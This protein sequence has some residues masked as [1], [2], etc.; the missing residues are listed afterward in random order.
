MCIS[1]LAV[2]CRELSR[3][4]G[5]H[6]AA[7]LSPTKLHR[8]G[9]GARPRQEI[10]GYSRCPSVH[11]S[12]EAIVAHLAIECRAT[13]VEALR[14]FRHVTAIATEREADHVRLHVLE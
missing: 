8:P 4:H 2:M 5:E 12:F 10:V 14:H 3:T 7:T 13:D 6:K 11:A 9:A 1:R